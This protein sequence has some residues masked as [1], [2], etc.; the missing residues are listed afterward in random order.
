MRNHQT[1]PHDRF[2]VPPSHPPPIRQAGSTLPL[3]QLEVCEKRLRKSVVA[4][5]TLKDLPRVFTK[6]GAGE[7]G[8][9]FFGG[10]KTMKRGATERGVRRANTQR[11]TTY[12]SL[13]GETTEVDEAKTTLESAR[14]GRIYEEEPGLKK[15][16][17]IPTPTEGLKL[18]WYE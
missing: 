15:D 13:T 16:N 7:L 2:V 6:R 9:G 14:P 1:H 3:E 11:F 17:S 4:S 8:F 5:P 10:G 18:L 12:L